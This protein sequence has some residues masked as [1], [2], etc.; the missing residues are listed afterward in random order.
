MIV[1][2]NFLR[3]VRGSDKNE[4]IEWLVQMIIQIRKTGE[5]VANKQDKI[6]LQ[7]FDKLRERYEKNKK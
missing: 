2:T 3:H 5:Y 4:V 6:M 1:D 7:K